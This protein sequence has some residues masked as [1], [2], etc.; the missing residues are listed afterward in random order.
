MSDQID[1]FTKWTIQ[2]LKFASEEA[3]TLQHTYIGAEHILLALIREESGVAAQVLGEL[4]VRLLQA[5]QAV[6]FVL[7][8]GRGT[9]QHD[10]D[11][12]V[13]G[14]QVMAYA[15][16][17]ARLLNHTFI[18]T[19]HV[20]LSLISNDE[21]SVVAILDL[22]GISPDRIRDAVIRHIQKGKRGGSIEALGTEQLAAKQNSQTP[23]LD[24]VGANLTELARAG[25]LDPVIGRQQE[26]ER[27]I[28]ILSR[29]TKNNPAL[30]G[31]PGVGKTAIVEGLAQHIVAG[32]VPDTIK[33]KQVVTLDIGALV[34]GTKYR[35]Q[36]EERLKHVLD[37]VKKLRAIL[38]IDEFHMLV[39][40][41][42][43]EGTLDAAN[44]LKPAL[45]RGELQT[46]GATTLDE[47]RKHIEQDAALERRFQP[48]VVEQP[49]EHDAYEIL[50]GLKKQYEEFH[51]LLISD[52]ALK[53]A[54]TLSTRYVPDRF[55]PDKAI[56]LIDEAAAHV[57]LTRLTTPPALR[58][59]QR[60]L[61]EIRAGLAAALAV[62]QQLTI[63]S[64]REREERVLGWIRQIEQSLGPGQPQP[65]DER[66]TVNADDVAEVLEI[67]T[68]I[69]VKRLRGDARARMLQIEQELH[70]RVVGQHEAIV[71]IAK[72]LRRAQAGLKDPRRPIGSFIFLGPTGVGKTELAKALAEFM[73]GTEERLIKLDMSEYQERHS[74]SRL[75]GS[76]PGYVGYDDGG[77]LTDIVR[78]RPY[79]VL[80]FDEIEKAHV[81]VFN[82]LLQ[83][84]DE[85]YLT[86]SKGRRVDFRNTIIILTSNL[87]A[88]QTPVSPPIGFLNSEPARPARESRRK[89]ADVALRQLFRPEFL[90]RIDATIA[91]QPLSGDDLRAIVLMLLKRVQAQ[92]R[93]QNIALD[94]RDDAVRLLAE[95]GYDQQLGA[96]PL[97]RVITSLLEDPLSEALLDDRF[98]A[99]DTVV[100][101]TAWTESGEPTLRLYVTPAAPTEPPLE[102]Y[103]RPAGADEPAQTLAPSV[104]DIRKVGR[105]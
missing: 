72:A 29:R 81:D 100:V 88:D 15:F 33:D 75:V 76:P 60:S 86:D 84:L 93:D 9:P 31:E 67:W 21:G 16:N 77:Q 78:R 87:G 47:Y 89:K 69:P 48:V 44:I 37:E 11:L 58:A 92:L 79:S 8:R 13:H 82:L 24:S 71:T 99:G 5:R 10:L 17:E 63:R 46:I 3:L 1:K 91:F 30:I 95:Q 65:G 85:G 7:G 43:Q 22:L 34:A 49:S 101:E 27:I 104:S 14:N 41:G 74:A 51:Q 102:D 36:F 45:S 62:G 32:D 80:L 4:G 66:A 35:G 83:V 105:P 19:E 73:F 70:R 52:E 12:T 28:K 18:G 64:L 59:A 23:Y 42:G 94:V 39:G 103:H 97:R 98:R 50:R 54:V 56:D 40:A 53:A 57:R 38:F 90:N 20:L 6:E 2:V 68:G 25:A 55:L 96:R 61:E 26:I